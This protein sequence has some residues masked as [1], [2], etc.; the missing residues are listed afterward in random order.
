MFVIFA[1]PVPFVVTPAIRVSVVVR[2]A[3]IS[4]RIGRFFVPAGN[5][6]IMMSLRRPEAANPY[7]HRRGRWWWRRFIGNRR[8]TNCNGDR[9]LTRCRQDQRHCEKQTASA[10]D[11]HLYLQLCAPC[12]DP[13]ES[14]EHTWR[15][16]HVVPRYLNRAKDPMPL[17]WDTRKQSCMMEGSAPWSTND[18]PLNAKRR[19][20]A[21][22]EEHHRQA[23]CR[24]A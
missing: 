22:L 6:A 15:Y 2:V 24:K 9:N 8:R 19:V 16:P 7:H 11:F 10:S 21:V 20:F 3:P 23:V 1:V 17:K 13:S 4:S 14:G 12:P 5:P 18:L